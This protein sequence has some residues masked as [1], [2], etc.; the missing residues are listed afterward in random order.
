M[1][2]FN[3]HSFFKYIFFYIFFCQILVTVYMFTNQD[4]SLNLLYKTV[5]FVVILTTAGLKTQ[6]LIPFVVTWN[7]KQYMYM[8]PLWSTLSLLPPLLSHHPFFHHPPLHLP[9]PTSSSPISL[10]SCPPP[11]E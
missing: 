4:L 9:S 10:L 7:I 6:T 8:T 11:L 2:N 3:F 1:N 5:V